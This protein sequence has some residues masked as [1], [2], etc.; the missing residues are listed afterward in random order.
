MNSANPTDDTSEAARATR[1]RV[2]FDELRD[3]L[4]AAFESLEDAAPA[5]LYPGEAGR[6]ELKPWVR[7]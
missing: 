1:A 7:A 6:F 5:H 4:V 3:R 2:W